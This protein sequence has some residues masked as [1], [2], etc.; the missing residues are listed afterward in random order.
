MVEQKNGTEVEETDI[1]VLPGAGQS[2]LVEGTEQQDV[3]SLM[4]LADNIDRIIEAKNKIRTA[5]Y[6]LAKPGDWVIFTSDK[7]VADGKE[8]TAEIGHAGAC[9]ISS[10]IGISFSAWIA[11]KDN[12]V[13]EKGPWYRWEA[14]CTASYRGVS[15]R[16]FGRAG[17]RDKFFGKAYGEMKDLSEINEG[18]IKMAA[19]RGC[20]KEGVKVLLGLHHIPVSELVALGVKLQ[21]AKGYKFSAND[22]DKAATKGTHTETEEKKMQVEIG[23]WLLEICGSDKEAAVSMIRKMTSFPEKKDGKP[24]GKTVEGVDSCEKLHGIRLNI[25]HSSAKSAYEKFSKEIG[26]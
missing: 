7:D 23:K 19:I 22:T 8:P 5:L 14:E 24:T 6:R 13:D 21:S 3:D 17:S 9:R 2:G 4:F 10:T 26:G 1:E 18:D 25:A 20:Q 11:R 16:V 12:G 15:V